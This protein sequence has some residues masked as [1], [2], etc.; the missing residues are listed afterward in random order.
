MRHR[1]SKPCRIS[2]HSSLRKL[3]RAARRGRIPSERMEV[4]QRAMHSAAVRAHVYFNSSP[5]KRYGW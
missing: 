1:D 5:R 2:E 4:I 3:M